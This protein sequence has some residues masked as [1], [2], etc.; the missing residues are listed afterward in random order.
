MVR[1]GMTDQD[2]VGAR[3]AN[4]GTFAVVDYKRSLVNTGVLYFSAGAGLGGT[5][6]TY[7][8]TSKTTI[9]DLY[10]PLYFDYKIN[11]DLALI[12]SPKYIFR[13]GLNQDV[14]GQSVTTTS[15]QVGL[16]GGVKIGQEKGVILEAAYTKELQ[17]AKTGYW[18]VMASLFFP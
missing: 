15:S 18:Q 13:T 5:S 6:I 2:E 9:I 11:E 1:Y 10:V 16:S 12:T 4:L 3:L 8:D 7:G 17:D 14:N